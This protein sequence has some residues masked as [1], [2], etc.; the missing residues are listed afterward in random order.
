M[1]KK[2]PE[3]IK[4]RV[5]E[6]PDAFAKLADLDGEGLDRALAVVDMPGSPRHRQKAT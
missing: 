2:V 1:A 6:R 5:F 3:K 4:R